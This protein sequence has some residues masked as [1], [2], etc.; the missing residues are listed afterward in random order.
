MLQDKSGIIAIFYCFVKQILQPIFA[1]LAPIVVNI[2]PSE[3]HSD[4]LMFAVSH[5]SERSP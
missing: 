5:Q 2:R 1:V 4:G 3:Q